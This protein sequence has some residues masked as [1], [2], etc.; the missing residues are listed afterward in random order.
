[1]DYVSDFHLE[2]L[3]KPRLFFNTICFRLCTYLV[4]KECLFNLHYFESFTY[5]LNFTYFYFYLF[6]TLFHILATSIPRCQASVQ[7]QGFLPTPR[8]GV[9]LRTTRYQ[10]P[11]AIGQVREADQQR[12]G[13]GQH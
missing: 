1:M 6:L 9:L 5:F 13:C 12:A 2:L 10:L 11:T 4:L 8:Q 7:D 3:G